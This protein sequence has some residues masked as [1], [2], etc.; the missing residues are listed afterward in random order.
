MSTVKRGAS[1]PVILA[2]VVVCAWGFSQARAIVVPFLIA[3]LIT[4]MTAPL[5]FRLTARRVPRGVAVGVG[6]LTSLV[7]LV[8]LGALL[9][10]A[11]SAIGGRLPDY[12]ERAATLITS[13]TA[14]LSEHG[15]AMQPD[16]LRAMVDPGDVIT[17]VS[18]LFR[19]VA[20]IVSRLTLVMLLVGFLLFEATTFRQKLERVLRD[21]DD[22]RSLRDGMRELNAYVAVKSVTS[23]ATGVLAGLA[24]WA[25]GV[26]VPLAWGLLA[27]LL[28]FIPT[29][30]SI[31]A[32][33]PPTLMALVMLGW[34]SALAVLTAYIGINFVIGNMI[35]PRVMGETLGLS[36]F[37]V[38]LGMVIW[39]AMLGPVGALLSGPLTMLL[40]IW[41]L[42][43][44]DLRW[45]G[46]LLGP[47]AADEAEAEPRAEATPAEEP[48]A[49]Q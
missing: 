49:A 45:L 2:A 39:Y 37:I 16:D 20:G 9:S 24:C 19:S 46:V 32:A 23:A 14:W 38:F 10:F 34:P 6:L 41:L 43:T 35:E 15:V 22:F 42:H 33:I 29:V 17:G 27:F 12:Q 21:E 18:T 3:L 44:E 31:I 36:P 8:G 26:D 28:N 30:G 40:R 25:V 7:A 5:V 47:A 4:A 13:V 1:A 11:M 48:A